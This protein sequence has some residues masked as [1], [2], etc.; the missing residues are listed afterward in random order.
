MLTNRG[1]L[2]L[3]AATRRIAVIGPL[4]DARA[5][6]LGPWALAGKAEDC[7]S[8]LEGLRSALPDCEIRYQ[9]GVTIAGEDTRRKGGAKNLRGR[10]CRH[11]V[12]GQVREH[13]RRGGEPG[14]AG[15]AGP[16]APTRRSRAGRRR[17]RNRLAVLRASADRAL[18]RRAVAGAAR[19]LVSRR[20]RRSGGRRGSHRT[21]RSHR[22]A[23]RH[24][25]TR[26]RP[27]SDFFR[28]R[29]GGRPEDPSN[30][31]TSKYIDLATAPQFPFGHG[32]S[33]ARVELSNLRACP[34]SFS[35]EDRIRVEVDATNLSDR[36]AR[37]TIFLF[38]HDR[39]AAAAPPM[40]EMKSWAK[41]ELGPRE[42]MTVAF[43]LDPACFR[44]L[45]ADLKPV[46]EPGEFDILVGFSA[47]R[48][49]LRTTRLRYR[50]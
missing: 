29:S 21:F 17:S 12:P 10:R 38:G 24:L 36:E 47:D 3:S 6:M 22:A 34:E 41:V 40:L 42:R 49:A 28:A 4:A 32:L 14:A 43:S 20:R 48:N 37:E 44:G 27:N 26:Q 1:A 5:E 7:A 15:I 50:A 33:Y 16:P 2:P 8:F 39:V 30:P 18:A 46:L 45:G 31:Y 9:P 19:H 25:A 23:R 35:S 13:E 11:S